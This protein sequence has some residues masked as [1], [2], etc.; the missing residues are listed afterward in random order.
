MDPKPARPGTAQWP[1]IVAIW[2]GIGLIDAC[3]TVFPMR[4][5]GMHHN[6]LALFF[7]LFVEF[8]PWMLA[9]RLV[10]GLGRRF[11]PARTS[12]L[13]TWGLHVSVAIGIGLVLSA[14]YVALEMGL[15]PWAIDP[16]AR[17]TFSDL[18]RQKFYSSVTT[19][20]VLYAF[21]LVIDYA[22]QSRKRIARQQT[23]AAQLGEQ[24][25]RAQ[26]D[27]LRRQ[28]EPHFMFNSLN[29]IAGLVRDNRNDD[30]VEMIV[31]LSD[32]LRHAATDSTRPQV[33]LAQ[34]VEHLRQYLEIQK[35]RFAERLQ[36]TLTIPPELLNAQVP[37][38]ILQP[39]VENA[40]K[41]G[42]AKRAQGGEIQVAAT[43]ANGVLNLR[44][45][46][47]GPCLPAEM[48]KKRTGIG[49]ANLRNRLQLMYGNRFELSLR[50]QATGGV[51]V[52][53][54]LPLVGA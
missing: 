19:S 23:E 33:P 20:L 30:A 36:V 11:P 28:V 16:H 5:Q 26:L 7:T 41:H 32:F 42:I 40:I 39:L 1:W 4:A 51:E 2:S 47:D 14:W 35:A 9:T 44:V 8:V 6:W 48:E 46:N 31:A 43:Q 29:S 22:L 15:N 45:G 49:I 21:V 17:G 37:S 3:E 18:L 34:E 12:S 25:S 50:N 10:I 38:L 27:A 54:S 52:S 13:S 24:L 53:I